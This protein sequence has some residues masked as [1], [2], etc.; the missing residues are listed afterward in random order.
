MSDTSWVPMAVVLAASLVASVTDFWRFKVYNALTWPLFLTALYYHSVL[1]T[2]HGLYA[3]LGGAAAG[4]LPLIFF[5]ALGGMGAGDVKLAAGVG[6]WIGA[7]AMFGVL[8]VACL[9]QGIY[10]LA[11]LLLGGNLPAVW[12][13]FKVLTFRML[14][15]DFGS[16]EQVVATLSRADRR[17]HA[18]PFAAMLSLG[19]IAHLAGLTRVFPF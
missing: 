18:I 12:S 19:L 2:G 3:A 9:A 10:A 13:R 17:R 16:D 11:L 7:T 5:Y 4:V 6:A 14:A 8:V 15:W 1:E